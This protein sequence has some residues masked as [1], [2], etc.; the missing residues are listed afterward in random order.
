MCGG[1][2]QWSAVRLSGT[3]ELVGFQVQ[4][5]GLIQRQGDISL[6]LFALQ[7]G[8]TKQTNVKKNIKIL[9]PKPSRSLEQK[10]NQAKKLL[11][12]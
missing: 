1:V 11:I 10:C 12:S 2:S 8:K 3:Q 9:G 4:V 5:L 7:E 6:A